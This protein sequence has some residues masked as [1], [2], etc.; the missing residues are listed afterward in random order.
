MLWR[1]SGVGSKGWGGT[2][3]ERALCPNECSGHGQCMAMAELA[4]EPRALPLAPTG[5]GGA[6]PTYGTAQQR[7]FGVRARAAWCDASSARGAPSCARG[8]EFA[9]LCSRPLP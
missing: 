3:C 8:A 2:A 4:R 5:R 1:T 9:D 7:N 6:F